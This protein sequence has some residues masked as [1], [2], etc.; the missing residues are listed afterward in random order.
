MGEEEDKSDDED[1]EDVYGVTSVIPL[2]EYPQKECIKEIKSTL[3]S[4]LPKDNEIRNKLEDSSIKI[5][6][7]VNERFTNLPP[8]ISLP[9]YQQLMN[10]LKS[11]KSDKQNKLNLE[12][13]WFLM[14]CKILKIKENKSK[15]PNE[16]QLI[17]V[18]AEEEFFD[19]L[20]D[21][22]FEYSVAKQCDSDVFDW[23]DDN[24]LMEPFRKV[25]LLKSENWNNSIIKLNEEFK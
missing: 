23:K 8:K 6:L 12:F 9:S 19:E 5:G 15:K 10:D 11:A 4:Y 16:L 1:D 13:E 3:L 2:I 18:N 14:V 24:N 20:S 17:Y 7:V 25:L 21:H 22:S